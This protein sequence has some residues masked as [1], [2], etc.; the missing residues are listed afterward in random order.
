MHKQIDN[1]YTPV[2]HSIFAPLDKPEEHKSE[3]VDPDF[4]ELKGQIWF[5][6][7]EFTN[8]AI[9]KIDGINSQD[10]LK[11]YAKKYHTWIADLTKKYSTTHPEKSLNP[12]ALISLSSETR[13]QLSTQVGHDEKLCDRTRPV[14]YMLS[15]MYCVAV[16]GYKMMLDFG[17]DVAA[18]SMMFTIPFEAVCWNVNLPSNILPSR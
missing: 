11:P 3:L 1:V 15:G 12:S 6:F 9:D 13:Q 14:V 5:S 17:S 10:D 7:K 8:E 4:Q 16:F 2:L 18:C